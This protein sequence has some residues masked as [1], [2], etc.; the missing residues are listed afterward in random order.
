MKLNIEKI[1]KEMKKNN[2]NYSQL[3][4]KMGFHRQRLSLVLGKKYKW[5]NL[6]TIEKFAL[7]F[8]LDPKDLIV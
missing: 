7:V 8:E 5:T 6:R 3:A 4:A 1:E 2:W